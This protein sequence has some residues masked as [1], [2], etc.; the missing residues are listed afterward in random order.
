MKE[1]YV[2]VYTVLL[3][4]FSFDTLLS[5]MGSKHD[6]KEHK[7]TTIK[8]LHTAKLSVVKIDQ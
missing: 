1:K 2:Y 8:V 4:A 3:S 6:L 5:K 7:E